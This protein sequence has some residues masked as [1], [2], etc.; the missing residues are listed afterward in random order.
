MEIPVLEPVPGGI[1]PDPRRWLALA[2]VLGATFLGVLDFFIVNVS[3]PSIRQD[4]H[5]T[6]SQIQLMI[7]GY[8]LTYAVC[9]I[10]GGRLGD[11]YGR[12]RV[13]MLGVA[14]FTLASALCG[15]A[16]GANTLIAARLLQGVTGAL[17]FPQV[18]SIIQVTFP[19]SERNAAFGILGMVLGAGS[20]MANVLGGFLIEGNLLGLGWRPI[21]LVNL[22]LGALA[23][24]A[25]PSILRESRSATALKLDLGGIPLAS[26]ALLLLVYPLAE[27]REAGWP[28]WAFICLAASVPALAVF[29]LYERRVSASGGSPLVELSLF[30]D[31]V[32]VAGLATSLAFY[33]GLSAFFMTITF[34][35]QDGLKLS[36][37]TAGYTLVP[38]GIG[39]L[40][41]SSLAVKLARRLGSLTINVGAGM[42]IIALAGIVAIA[43]WHGAALSN[44]E[45]VPLL[46]LY[47][48][49]QG[50]VMPTLITTVL[51]G[52]PRDAAGS[53]SGVLTTTQQVALALGVALI[54]TIFFA[55]LGGEPQPQEF[56][57]AISTSLLVNIGLLAA[58]FALAFLL[59]RTLKEGVHGKHIDV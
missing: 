8:G 7:A 42:M 10:T 17:M 24:L 29:I 46:L 12:K 48:T 19:P 20:F 45:L 54:G 22:P 13:F 1:E 14:G 43:R 36:P 5:A 9:L 41:A 27:G 6:L 40:M 58:T 4:L 47:G 28:P 44:W 52:I 59:P 53:A 16:P 38:F 37:K 2:V 23:L 21:F 50:F 55:L 35:L 39:F 25:A 3:I 30:G 56:A 51:S 34:F 31:R 57:Q 33:S 18:L 15:L 26:L 32:F 11:I 49:G